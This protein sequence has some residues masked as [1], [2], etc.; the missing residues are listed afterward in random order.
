M[1]SER[2]TKKITKQKPLCESF[3]VS[4]SE[5]LEAPLLL[6]TFLF[7]QDFSLLYIPD[8][9]TQAWMASMEEK[10]TAMD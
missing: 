5:V 3:L 10:Q 6:P 9:E 4:Y 8:I 7:L 2:R 1:K